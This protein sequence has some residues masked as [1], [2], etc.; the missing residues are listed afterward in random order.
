MNKKAIQR[1]ATR[2]VVRRT[3]HGLTVNG[4][5][6]KLSGI[7]AAQQY[8]RLLD[9]T[10]DGHKATRYQ[11]LFLAALTKEQRSKAWT[12]GRVVLAI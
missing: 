2:T 8:A 12:P 1:H 3:R 9:F 6:I 4:R 10:R 5:F 7:T 11:N